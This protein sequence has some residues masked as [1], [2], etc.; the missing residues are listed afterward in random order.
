MP[1]SQADVTAGAPNLESYTV[2]GDG[3]VTDKVTG[4]MWQQIVPTTAAGTPMTFIWTDAIAYCPALNLGGHGDWRL[5]SFIELASLLDYGQPPGALANTAAFP[6]TPSAV[7]W[8]SSPLVGSTFTAWDVNFSDGAV[9]RGA[10]AALYD[11]R[12]VR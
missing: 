7:F 2:N 10:R 5:P 1:N 6:G 3:T 11:V 9:A 8:S 4:L 12:C